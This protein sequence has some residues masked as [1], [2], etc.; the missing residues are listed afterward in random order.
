MLEYIE[1]V[2]VFCDKMLE[3][4]SGVIVV[5]VPFLWKIG[6]CEGHIQDPVSLNKLTGWFGFAPSFVN[7]VDDRLIAVFIKDDKTRECLV[8]SNDAEFTDFYGEYAIAR[9]K[10]SCNVPYGCLEGCRKVVIYGAGKVGKAYYK[11]LGV[12][13]K[14]V[15]VKWV[16]RDYKKYRQQGYEVDSPESIK[17]TEYDVILIAV[18]NED[19]AEEIMEYTRKLTGESSKIVWE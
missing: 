17:E 11:E 4:S 18:Q 13:N 1:N 15:V 14:Y 10:I 9:K 2:K 3:L 16:D 8:E 6:A 5:S 19:V 12:Q 7:V